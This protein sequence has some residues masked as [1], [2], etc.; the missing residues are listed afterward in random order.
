[1]NEPFHLYACR[2]RKARW[3]AGIVIWGGAGAKIG[4]HTFRSSAP[5]MDLLTK[6]GFTPE[7]VPAAAKEQVA[8]SRRKT[9]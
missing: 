8:K 2:S 6:F 1:M 3:P 7:K 5:T 9:V 4:M